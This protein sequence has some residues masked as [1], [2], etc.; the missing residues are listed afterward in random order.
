M[1]TKK[2]GRKLTKKEILLIRKHKIHELT[3]RKKTAKNRLKLKRHQQ[4][5][6]QLE[7]S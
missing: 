1:R 3:K 5:I 6:K 7:K 2:I 4:V